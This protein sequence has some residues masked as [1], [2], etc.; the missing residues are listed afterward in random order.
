ME[1]PV[2]SFSCAGRDDLSVHFRSDFL[3]SAQTN[4]RRLHRSQHRERRA[5][6]VAAPSYAGP[7]GRALS[8]DTG[9]LLW[10]IRSFDDPSER[11][12]NRLR[13]NLFERLQDLPISFFDA[14]GHG[15]VMSRFTNDADNVQAAIEQ[16]ITSFFLLSLRFSAPCI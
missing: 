4:H 15:E 5:G 16:G 3:L 13:A 12:T 6:L 11:C 7:A 14:H 1:L 2:P 9:C 10:T 8:V